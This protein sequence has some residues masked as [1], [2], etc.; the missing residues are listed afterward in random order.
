MRNIE[1]KLLQSVHGIRDGQ[2]QEH[3][4]VKKSTIS[5][6]PET[7]WRRRRPCNLWNQ[8]TANS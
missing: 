3:S 6:V 5:P 7:T 4:S 2:L 8:R 1:L